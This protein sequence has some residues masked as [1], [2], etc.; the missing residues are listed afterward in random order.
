MNVVRS[1][2]VCV[3]IACSFVAAYAQQG[4]PV[5]TASSLTSLQVI[6]EAPDSATGAT[7][8]VPGLS[9]SDFHLFD[10]KHEVAVQGFTAGAQSS[11]QPIALW[12]IV[13]CHQAYPSTTQTSEKPPQYTSEFLSGHAQ[14]LTSAL[15]HLHKDD[16]IGLAHWCGN[17]DIA[18]DYMP[19]L[20]I[21]AVL[22]GINNILSASPVMVNSPTAG[23]ETI[24]QLIE[25]VL[26]ETPR[27]GSI[28]LISRDKAIPHRLPVL[29]FLNGDQNQIA[30]EKTIRF[31]DFLF[32]HPAII[33]G[34]NI[35]APY[36]PP[37][38]L[39]LITSEADPQEMQTYYIIHSYSQKTGGNFYSVTNFNQLPAILSYIIQ[40]L[41]ERYT[42]SFIPEKRDG[43]RHM[44]KVEL[45]GA[46]KQQFPNI[47]LRY[48]PQYIPTPK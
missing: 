18:I 20:D 36:T 44:L 8:L 28:E 12:L 30:Y 32:N 38:K 10:N 39:P 11:A 2:L 23:A 31:T 9:R 13:Q 34:L 48:R 7:A 3:F 46:A 24:Q 33:F 26:R 45:T 27:S 41:H 35:G 19:G 43:K 40:Q 29:L 6:A 22:A 16:A 15:L 17:G 4:Q 47:E 25:R 5:S 37:E 42:L 14:I 1:M 21:D